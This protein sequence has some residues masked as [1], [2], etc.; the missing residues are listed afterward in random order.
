M[1]SHQLT[2]T[3]LHL[4]LS[5]GHPIEHV[6]QSLMSGSDLHAVVVSVCLTSLYAL[7]LPSTAP[8]LGRTSIFHVLVLYHDSSQTDINL[9]TC[10]CLLLSSQQESNAHGV[11]PSRDT[12]PA[13]LLPCPLTL[14]TQTVFSSRLRHL[15]C[16]CLI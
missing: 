9:I 3:R 15:L 16:R 10:T 13:L 12:D 5:P 1:P 11:Y 14:Q 8:S 4:S 6:S 7:C 2:H